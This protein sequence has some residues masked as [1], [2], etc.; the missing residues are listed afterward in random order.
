MEATHKPAVTNRHCFPHC[1]PDAH[2]RVIGDAQAAPGPREVGRAM[3]AEAVIPS[4][5]GALVALL[6]G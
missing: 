2:S 1:D 3:S 5:D 4:G 6:P